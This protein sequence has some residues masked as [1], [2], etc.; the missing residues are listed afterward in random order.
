MGMNGPIDFEGQ[1]KRIHPSRSDIRVELD[2]I[3]LPKLKSS[4]G[5]SFFPPF[6][7]FVSDCV[8]ATHEF[9]SISWPWQT[10]S[11]FNSLKVTLC[12]YSQ[13]RLTTLKNHSHHKY[14]YL[15]NAK[16]IKFFHKRLW[17]TETVQQHRADAPASRLLYR[18][19]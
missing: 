1:K 4:S 9:Q 11:Y 15:G 19:V 3:D 10:F 14:T 18:M 5:V 2:L 13:L 12:K 6:L 16:R 7:P 8:S 17:D